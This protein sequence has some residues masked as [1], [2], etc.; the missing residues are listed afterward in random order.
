MDREKKKKRHKT[1]TMA[2]K[3]TSRAAQAIKRMF[4]SEPTY[5]QARKTI[6][7]FMLIVKTHKTKTQM[8]ETSIIA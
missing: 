2:H 7:L 1:K 6:I 3:C 4:R 5:A 8:I